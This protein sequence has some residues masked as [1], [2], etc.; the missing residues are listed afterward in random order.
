MEVS[1]LCKALFKRGRLPIQDLLQELNISLKQ[2][3]LV[4]RI[5]VILL[6]AVSLHV[7]ARSWSQHITLS[8]KSIPVEKVFSYLKQQTGYS[9]L[10]DNKLLSKSQIVSVDITNGTLEEVLDQCLS[11]LELTYQVQHKIVY[12][13][14]KTAPQISAPQV[15]VPI[16][17]TVIVVTADGGQPLD[18]ASVMI[19]GNKIGWATNSNGITQLK[20]I[21]PDATLVISYAGYTQQ[22]IKVNNRSSFVIRLTASTS[23]LDQIQIVAYGT[24]TKRYSTGSVGQVKSEDIDQQPVSNPILAME[25]R[26]PGVFITQNAGYSGA[27]M[28]V[29]IRGQTSFGFNSNGPLYIVDGIPFN[30]KPVEQT[31]GGYGTLGFSP[32]NTISPA[33]IESINVLKDADATAIYGSRGANGVILITTKKGKMGNTKLDADI[34]SGWSGVTHTIP[35]LSTN[36]YLSIRRQAFANDGVTPTTTNA[37]DLTLWDQN[38][39]TNF[40]KLLTGNTSHTTKATFLLS[41]GDL[42]TQFL[43]G[44]N[45][46]HESTVL[47]AHTADNAVQFHLNLQHKSRNNKFGTTV[48]VSY[49]VDNNTI[50]NY[51]L[52]LTNYSLPPNY[53]LYNANGSLYFGSSYTSPLAAFNSN[54]NLQSTNLVT[55]AGVHYMILP[56]LTIKANAGYNYDNVFGSTISPASSFNPLTNYSQ[57]S[58][59]N[60]NY[61][62][63]YIAEPQINYTHTWGKG[64]LS[65]LAGGSWQE[66]QTVQPYFL[67]GAFTNIQLATSLSALTVLLKSSGYTDYKYESGFG[68][69]E[70]VWD[71]KYLFSGN[72]RRDGSSRFGAERAFGTFGSGAA[73]WIFSKESF[74]RDNLPWLS[75]GKIRTSYGTV[76]SDKSIGDYAYESTYSA[77]S[78]YGPTSSLTPLRILNPY[79]QWEVTKK[80]DVA[81]ELGFLHDRVLFS[82]D[83]YRNRSSNL[84]GAT[85]LPAQDGFS[86]YSANLPAVVQ[87][88]GIELELSTVTIKTKELIWSTSFN[89]TIPQNKLLSFPNILNSTYANTYVVGQSLNLRTIFHS[90][91]IVNGIATV[92]D[93]NHDGV[94]T[95]GYSATGKSDYIIDGNTDPKFYGGLDNTISY[96]GFQFDFLF[97]FTKRTAMRGDLNFAT[98]PGMGYNLPASMLNLPLK[99]SATS[100]SAASSA[101]FYYTASDAAVE[102]ASFIRLK[103]VSLAYNIPLMWAKKIKVSAFQVYLHGQNLLTFTKYKGLDPE[104]LTTSLPPLKMLVAGIKATF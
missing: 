74:V 24:T 71:G 68:R 25:G 10:W 100:G 48:S 101:Y 80:L 15:P 62:K 94:I 44:G 7:S 93:V 9:F 35:M 96:K 72:I 82:A 40:P 36:Q 13:V 57:T 38:A 34:S 8:S 60:N 91:G 37:P 79:L 54:S 63:T 12:I 64:R 51:N 70:Y 58:Q 83:F 84:L 23:V 90:T 31:V 30:D 3:L 73:A 87:N 76:G 18:G 81:I 4:M 41:G 66:T 85:P 11:G 65:A 61:I 86:S 50:P 22:E 32:L 89:L 39:Y 53:P 56:G 46:R 20:N 26:I 78:P 49:N 77:G 19:K 102:D 5:T 17:V 16:T 95:S 33:E 1:I 69:L 97:Q 14:K 45:Y 99:Y 47:D 52:S 75:F 42:Y 29:T 27:T 21:D 104:T 6:F 67:L 59:L 2:T 43:F 98:Y 55:S 92:E 103:N 88:K 28:A